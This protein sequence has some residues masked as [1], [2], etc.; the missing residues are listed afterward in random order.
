MATI[1]VQGAGGSDA[2]TDEINVETDD[3]ILIVNGRHYRIDTNDKGELKFALI[4]G[5]DCRIENVGGMWGHA[6]PG[7][8]L[9]Q[10]HDS[11]VSPTPE[12]IA[13][14]KANDEAFYEAMNEY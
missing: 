8:V 11:R 6:Y 9:T 2:F 14:W 10:A 12:Q 4:N 5:V 7:I 3:F 13:K 1:Q